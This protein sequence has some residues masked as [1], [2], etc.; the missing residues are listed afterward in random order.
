M[1]QTAEV[2]AAAWRET[3][4]AFL[5]EH[6]ERTGE[7]FRPFELPADY[8][9]F[10]DGRLR[11]DGVRAFLAS[12]G[13]DLPEGMPDDPPTA[14]TVCGLATRKNDRVLELIRKQGVEAYEGSV[15]FVSAA[16]ETGLG[17]AVVSA[18]ENCR[19]VLVAAN[20]NHLFEARVDGVVAEEAGLRG[21]PAPDMFLAATRA[22][23][24]D[25]SEAAVFEDAVP[26]VAAGQAGSFAWVV[27][28][29]RVGNAEALRA[30]GA[31]IVV[32]DL[33]E[34]LEPR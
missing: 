4:D 11:A 29:D 30:H 21:K 12:R 9:A 13:I 3:F 17:R 14:P 1:T 7:S 18:S 27:G 24:V 8:V 10:V 22:L 31:D 16:R 2:H 19:D 6:A 32:A 34:L 33:S 28:V 20:I 25:P 5:V 26:G 15:R 23:R